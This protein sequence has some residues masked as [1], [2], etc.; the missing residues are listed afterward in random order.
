MKKNRLK[1]ALVI[2]VCV[3]AVLILGGS[4]AIGG[5]ISNKILNQNEG[6]DTSGNS[7]KQ[8]EVWGYDLDAFNDTYS[9]TE[10]EA[11]AADGNT[12]PA[13]FFDNGSDRCVILVHGAGGDRVC[14]YPL[15]E[16]YLKRGYDVIAIDQRGC[17]KNP[18]PK[19]TFGINESLDV[20]AMVAYARE[21]LNESEVIVHGQSMGAQTVAIYAS[22]AEPGKIEAADAVIC[23][24][25]VPGM[26][27]MLR[28][29]FGES[30]EAAYSPMTN[31]LIG[32]SKTFMKV[33]N[34]IDWAD[35]DTIALASNIRIPVMIIISDKDEVCLPELVSQ[36]YDN[37]VCEKRAIAHV[38]SAH[39]EGIID[40]PDGYMKNV[41][42][43]LGSI[44]Q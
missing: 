24:S 9:G 26:E 28:L 16:E 12:V 22:K 31:Y 4:I 14:T 19:V 35:G 29:A 37:I 1:K 6:K 5:L 27:L 2:T 42:D 10:I 25:P 32:T 34:G 23:D 41:E 3:I 13:T 17:G 43:F 8:L 36:I 20:E 38:D 40:D 21:N 39:I 11:K 33:A 7:V 44:G 18:D 15:A 30:V